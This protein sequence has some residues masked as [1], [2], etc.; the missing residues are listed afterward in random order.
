[1]SSERAFFQP[2]P[3]RPAGPR[4]A[5][6]FSPARGIQWAALVLLLVFLGGCAGET[7][8]PVAS[9]SPTIA[10]QVVQTPTATSAARPT[11]QQSLAASPSAAAQRAEPSPT[12][13]P[14]VAFTYLWPAYIP[15]DMRVSPGESRVARE[16]EI[17]QNGL[18][19]FIVTFAAGTGRLVIGGGAT[20]TLPL[21][22]DQRRIQVAGRDATLTTGAAGRQVVFDMPKGSL[23]V[24]S[25]T[26]SEDELLHVAGSLQPI[27]VAELRSRVEG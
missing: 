10:A 17:G 22:G 8:A 5:W 27:D 19:F 26:L 4:A 1:M 12:P 3:R 11:A 9:P 20:E 24:Y 23:F 6:V 7:A 13:P 21:T 14:Q 15:A 2:V 16:G 25:S 18:G